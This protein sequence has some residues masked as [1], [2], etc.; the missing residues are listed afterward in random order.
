VLLAIRERGSVTDTVVIQKVRTF[1][2]E[3]FLY[4]RPGYALG[5]QDSLLDRR[6]LD[7]MGVMELVA[8]L[9]NEFGVAVPEEDISE[10]HLGTLQAI[11]AYVTSARA[12]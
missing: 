4:M 3:N 6:I 8:F 2:Q 7:S 5:D 12:G 1:I 11:A 10:A 9:R